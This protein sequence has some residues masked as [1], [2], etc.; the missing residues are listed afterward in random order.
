MPSGPIDRDPPEGLSTADLAAALN[1]TGQ[2]VINWKTRNLLPSPV[3]LH[4]GAR[5]R[6]SVWPPFTL[7]L[8]RFVQEA[9]QARKTVAQVARLVRPLLEKDPSWIHA[10]LAKGKSISDLLEIL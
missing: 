6:M 1:V 5:G 10:E 9:L 4:L 8:A 3:L 7:P 2:T